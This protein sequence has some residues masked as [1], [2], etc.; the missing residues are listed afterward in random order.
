MGEI[1]YRT[2]IDKY[3]EFKYWGFIDGLFVSPPT[4]SVS[5]QECL[6]LSEQYTGLKDKNGKEIYDGD[7]L[8]LYNYDSGV[9]SE[10]VVVFEN[11]CFILKDNNGVWEYIHEG[12]INC[13]FGN[14]YE[15]PELL[16]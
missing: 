1:K 2:W 9:H 10:G 14:I 11:G 6:E 5:M 8:H 7:F 12:Y 16:K 4:G 15:T 13:I 3:K